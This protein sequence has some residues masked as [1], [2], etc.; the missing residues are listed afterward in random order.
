MYEVKK[1]TGLFNF[2]KK[3]GLFNNLLSLHLI[4]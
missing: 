1:L 3:K 4:I 2:V